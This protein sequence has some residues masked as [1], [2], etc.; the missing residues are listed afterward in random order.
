[1]STLAMGHTSKVALKDYLRLTKPRA[2]L[3]HFITATSAMCL[4]V[5]GLPQLNTLLLTLAGGGLVAAGSNTLNCYFDH[6]LDGRMARTRC[7]PLPA[8]RLRPRQALVFGMSTG[9]VGL[10]VL[11]QFVNLA[12]AILAAAALVYYALIYTLL[13]KRH[14][15]WSVLIGS[16]AGAITPLIG[17]VAVTSR[18]ES[19]PFILSAIIILWTLPHFWTLA[20]FRRSDYEQAGLRVL[21]AGG[22]NSWIIACSLLLVATTLLF[23]PAAGLS[24]FYLGTAS[25]LGS[26]FL[27]LALRMSRS[28]TLQTAWQL[29]SYSIFYISV[30]FGAMILDRSLF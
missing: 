27:Y 3:P 2:I 21:P 23:V 4:A 11:G 15:R 20:I 25:V 19:T 24:Y 26:V 12:A 28:K 8:G 22:V 10:V 6:E 17:W 16:G 18:I 29:Y 9:L 13:L 30:L 7:R 14:T 1:M 5:S